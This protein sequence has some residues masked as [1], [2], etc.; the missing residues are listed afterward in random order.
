[1]G[2]TGRPTCSCT[3]L[4]P[5]APERA[6]IA[7]ATAAEP[8]SMVARRTTPTGISYAAATPATSTPSKAPVRT[9]PVTRPR[10]RACSSDVAAAKS[11][12]S[13]RR[14]SACDPA[15]ATPERTS[16]AV[17]TSST[18]SVG[19]L[20]GGARSCSAR[21]PTPVRRWVSDPER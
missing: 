20:A 2:C 9:S 16:K 6:A 15:P 19:S 4:S 17:S 12:S 10:N 8:A 21:Q 1:M 18:D 5:V 11:S 7:A 3:S 14:R 13:R